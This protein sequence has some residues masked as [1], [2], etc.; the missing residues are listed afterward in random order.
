MLFTRL[1]LHNVGVFGGSHAIELRPLD[2]ARPLILVGGLNGLGKTTILEAVRLCLYGRRALGPRPT[3]AEYHAY[4]AEHIHHGLEEEQAARRASITLE[5]EHGHASERAIYR[6][7]RAW[8]RRGGKVIDDLLVLQEG[9]PLDN[10]DR[11]HWQAFIDNLI[12]AP[13]SQLFFFDGER[14]QALADDSEDNVELA[15]AFRTL[16]GLD[17][18]EQL[19]T[20]LA[21]Y[22]SRQHEVN[23]A[24]L[25]TRLDLIVAEQ[26]L[27]QDQLA[28]TRQDAAAIRTGI[29][30]QHS[31][32]R[33]QED[34]LIRE[35][36]AFAEHRLTLQGQRTQLET[37]RQAI[38]DEIRTLA[39]GLLPF[40]LAPELCRHALA[41]LETESLLDA[42]AAEN[43]V[44]F[45]LGATITRR[46]A[47]PELWH[48]AQLDIPAL[49][50]RDAVF[51][52]L[53]AALDQLLDASIVD[54]RD[55]RTL[56][57]LGASDRERVVS[58]LRRAADE[59]VKHA[60][61]LETRLA[62]I[63]QAQRQVEHHLR[64]APADDDVRPLV[65]ELGTLHSSLGEL[66]LDLRTREQR[67]H[68]LTISADQCQREF[69][70][71]QIALGQMEHGDR[72]LQ[73]SSQVQAV[74]REF[75]DALGTS[76]IE[77]LERTIVRCFNRLAR[78]KDLV[79]RVSIEPTS[80]QATLYGR[81]R[82]V[83]PRTRLSAGEKQIY[84][85]SLLWSLAQ[86]SGRQLP[87]I[88]D[89]PLGRLDNAHR[90]NLV[91]HYFPYA[92]EQILVL[93]TDS[94]FDRA[95]I[96]ELLPAISRVYRLDYDPVAGS[97]RVTP[98]Y[99][100]EGISSEMERSTV[101]ILDG[102]ED[103]DVNI[104]FAR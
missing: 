56:H 78:K 34:R 104:G 58:L 95:L 22:Q 30:H 24:D 28:Q 97:S 68:E 65:D 60:R 88:I 36:G 17:L 82:C 52:Q 50:L 63:E 89:T 59:T 93:S 20:D 72:R 79:T 76:R 47:S 90:R 14:I 103:D 70:R 81:D 4:L 98:G 54:S 57:G 71:I 64:Q 102:D 80:F 61:A 92:A 46:L 87:M 11:T 37:E 6:V 25:R 96:E 75:R 1:E 53:T 13:L 31:L 83:L 66:E 94:E 18:V 41:E 100:W 74:L 84:A 91:N 44:R 29:D 49:V 19:Q 62:T 35:G 69:D 10:L 23:G 86:V 9:R 45:D 26:R 15:A 5:F 3:L 43:R 40:A 48:V 99:L 21:V 32:I 51:P 55:R 8:E 33:R 42:Q 27:L 16:L 38:E 39:A 77:Q 85:I 73:L 101:T 67:I 2:R 12:P 7:Q